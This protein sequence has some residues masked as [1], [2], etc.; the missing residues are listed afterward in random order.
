M[1]LDANGW[2]DI[3]ELIEKSKEIKLTRKLINE[4][5]EENDKQLFIIDGNRIRANQGDSIVVGKRHGTVV[6]LELEAKKMFDDGYE[7]YVSENAV[8]LTDIVP[9]KFINVKM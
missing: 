3:D 9:I 6:I 1:K 8:W 2:A 7:F 4:V 5:V